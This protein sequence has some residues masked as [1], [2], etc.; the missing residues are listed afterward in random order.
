[1]SILDRIKKRRETVAE[2]EKVSPDAVPAGEVKIE[3]KDAEPSEPTVNV[4]TQA[5]PSASEIKDAPATEPPKNEP[6]STDSDIPMVLDSIPDEEESRIIETIPLGDEEIKS[7]NAHGYDHNKHKYP[8]TYLIEKFFWVNARSSDPS[9][10]GRR[11]TKVKR[12]AEIRA[13]SAMH[14][15]GMIGWNDKNVAVVSTTANDLGGIDVRIDGRSICK[16][17]PI[18]TQTGV[19]YP[20]LGGKQRKEYVATLKEVAQKIEAVKSELASK[21]RTVVGATYEPSIAINL[22]TEV[23]KV[24]KVTA[25]ALR[26]IVPTE[27]EIAV[28][29]ALDETKQE[30]IETAG[31]PAVLL[32][33]SK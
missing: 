9:N 27:T 6:T 23:D 22:R 10:P 8:N 33:E 31:V 7:L 26:V 32:A 16:M 13:V 18:P 14:A 11:S 15:L 5:V 3:V 28:K 4:E 1:M 30:L 21:M 25:R 29:K 20:H 24:A 2:Q 17:A 19:S 12:C